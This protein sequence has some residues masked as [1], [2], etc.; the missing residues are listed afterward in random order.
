[1]IGRHPRRTHKPPKPCDPR[2]A[3]VRRRH[4]GETSSSCAPQAYDASGSVRARV[5][6]RLE[7][8]VRMEWDGPLLR[9]VGWKSGGFITY[10][11]LG[12]LDG[13]ELDELIARQVRFFADRNERFE[14]KLHGH[15]GPPTLTERLRVAGFVPE[16]LE[17]V[18][19]ASSAE[20]AAEPSLP[21][22]V[23]LREV[24]ERADFDRIAAHQDA[25][26]DD[27]HAWLGE[28]LE[29]EQA[30]DP[31]SL[32]VI[33]AEHDGEIVCATAWVRFPEH[34]DFAI[35][36]GRCDC[37]GFGA[38]GASIAPP[39]PIAPSLPARRG[40]RYLEVDASADSRPI[41]ERLGFHAVTT[42]TP[43]IWSPPGP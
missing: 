8:G 42:T 33:V 5:P 4:P 17:T 16:E 34:T 10:R 27:P 39:S 12:G 7:P 15:D 26:W 21:D 14:W 18:M 23:S 35:A 37:F 32:S 40:L 11:D 31:N 36:L 43:F 3:E 2:V 6:E 9:I 13:P 20:I 19:I 1:M 22:G 38:V 41:L 30:T 24:T 29:S 28:T 25:V